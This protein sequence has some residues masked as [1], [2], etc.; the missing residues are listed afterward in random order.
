M[1]AP[2]VGELVLDPACGTGGF[3]V[4]ALDFVRGR[5]VRTPEQEADPRRDLLGAA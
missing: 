5:E 2:R 4:N 3:L 1:T